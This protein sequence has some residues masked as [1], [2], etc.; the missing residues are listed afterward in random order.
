LEPSEGYLLLAILA[1]AGAVDAVITTNFDMLLERA[2]RLL[3]AHTFQ[4]FAPGVA[5]PYADD[6]G[7]HLPN[8]PVYLK[9]HGDIESKIITHITDAEITS[10]PYKS[11]LIDLARD[12]FETHHLVFI[13]YSGYDTLLAEHLK[14]KPN[15]NREVY[16]INPT[17]LDPAAPISEALTGNKII[18]IRVGFEQF[19]HEIAAVALRDVD[20]FSEQ[21]IFIYSIVKHRIHRANAEFLASQHFKSAGTRSN[22]YVRRKR[23]ERA[24]QSFSRDAEKCLGVITGPSGCGKST[25]IAAMCDRQKHDEFPDVI[26][27]RATSVADNDF[28]RRIV[29]ELHDGLGDSMAKLLQFSSWL[30]E[31]QKQLLIVVDGLNEYSTKSDKIILFIRSILEILFRLRHHKSIKVLITI[32]RETWNAVFEHLDPIYLKKLLWTDA[33]AD[34]RPNAIYLDRFSQSECAEALELYSRQFENYLPPDPSNHHLRDLLTDPF[35]LRVFM[36]QKVSPQARVLPTKLY[37]Y[38]FR[39]QLLRRWQNFDAKAIEDALAHLAEDGL[40]FEKYCF[41]AADL[42]EAGL[43][44][45]DL[46]ELLDAHIITKLKDR[47]D[48]AFS[49]DRIHE[50]FIA[51]AIKSGALDLRSVDDVED[52]LERSQNY[53]RIRPSLLRAFVDYSHHESDVWRGRIKDIISEISTRIVANRRTGIQRLHLFF[54]DLVIEMAKVNPEEFIDLLEPFVTDP[55]PPP[56]NLSVMRDILQGAAYLGDEMALSFLT[57]VLLSN[58]GVKV[59]AEILLYDRVAH[60]VIL[61]KRGN[62]ECIR[63]DPCAKYF[64]SPRD[65][66]LSKIIKALG[67][68]TRIGE[69]NLSPEEYEHLEESMRGHLKYILDLEYSEG[70]SDLE[71]GYERARTMGRNYATLSPEDLNR[72]LFN[73]H[74]SFIDDYYQARKGNRL[75]PLVRRIAGG[76]PLT[77]DDIDIVRP[78]VQG[79]DDIVSFLACNIIFSE[80]FRL[81]PDATNNIFGSYFARFDQYTKAGEIDFFLSAVFVAHHSNGV[82]AQPLIETYMRRIV[83]ELPQAVFLN[84]GMERAQVHLL[85]RDDFDQQ[86]E[87]GFNPLAVYFY[88]APSEQRRAVDLPRYLRSDRLRRT[89]TPLYQE[90]LSRYEREGKARG[91]I[92]VIHALGQMISIWPV[93]GLT[94]LAT[95]VGRDEPTVRRA[96]RRVLAEA[97][98]RFPVQTEMVMNQSGAAFDETALYDIRC[99]TDPRMAQ[100]TQEQ[101]Q[102]CRVLRFLAA[103]DPSKTLFLRLA[104]IFVTSESWEDALGDVAAVVFQAVANGLQE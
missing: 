100:R 40:Q 91:I 17:P 36:E 58:N 50:Y 20:V 65:H 41:S 103:V 2:Q 68:L 80:S 95:Q 96:V 98:A 69:D 46:S 11:V 84:P 19:M 104:E 87:D 12:I 54:K 92:R 43:R 101:L 7:L 42:R 93:E 99:S 29:S 48:Y 14:Q 24:I 88:N 74:V 55:Q 64:F 3:G 82:A 67:L 102:Y 13:G 52:A 38:A 71:R 94:G 59:D 27:L 72:Y 32:R 60:Y 79:V 49:H 44:Q 63:Q 97:F 1:Q 62:I 89:F 16:W 85:Y 77:N 81:D 66:A 83:D 31:R 30:R 51:E 22:I 61:C 15:K 9:L 25:I 21:N 33:G 73:A 34:D 70:F 45:S 6:N 76:S 37:A 78:A 47:S 18:N 86:F 39:A 10:R 26:A 28:P 5:L 35:L 23:V 75:L 53:P 90:L 57:N 56:P 8:R 4:I